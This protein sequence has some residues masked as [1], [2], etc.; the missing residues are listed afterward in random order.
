[1]HVSPQLMLYSVLSR[2]FKMG[3][4][5][6]NPTTA[7]YQSLLDKVVKPETLI[8]AEFGFKSD[9]FKNSL[10]I[11]GAFFKNWWQDYQF[12]LVNNPGDPADLFASLVNLPEAKS[13]GA[14]LDI[15][16]QVSPSLRVNL[17]VGWLDSQITDGNLDTTGIPE[18]NIAGFQNQV[19]NGNVLT[20]TP[21][22]NYNVLAVK[23]YQLTNS[24]I[25]LSLHLSY[26]GKHTHQLEGNNSE[27]WVYN[28]SEN[29][30]ALLTVNSL[31]SF[32]SAR[33]YQIA[34]WAKNLTNE[35]YCSE[36]SIAP[37]TSPEFIRLCAQ[38]ESRSYGVT[39]KIRF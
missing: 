3:A 17:G 34:L 23:S 32:G 18:E 25:E 5:N 8:T 15:V 35:Q 20:N 28:F 2:G 37:G 38:G 36:R 6:S 24:D 7:A 33:E 14:E 9:L 4:V 12:F 26:F 21:K 1:Y 19:V 22:W 13:I 27:A 39:G 10:R 31:W 11:N 30:T 29:S 16:W